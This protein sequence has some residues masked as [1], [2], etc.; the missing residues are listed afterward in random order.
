MKRPSVRL[1]AL[2]A[3]LAAFVACAPV[4]NKERSAQGNAFPSP[5]AQQDAQTLVFVALSGGTGLLP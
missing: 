4:Y 2:G 1:V 3:F 5:R